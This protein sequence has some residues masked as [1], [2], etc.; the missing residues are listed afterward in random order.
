MSAASC[1]DTLAGDDRK[2][3]IRLVLLAWVG[4]LARA[5][6]CEIR[7]GQSPARVAGSDGRQDG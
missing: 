4:S 6:L 2:A 7:S 3:S 1:A 5:R